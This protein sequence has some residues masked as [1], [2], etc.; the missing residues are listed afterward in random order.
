MGY[1][2]EPDFAQLFTN[3]VL[4]TA[5]GS[6]RYDQVQQ[7][8]GQKIED[9]RTK[10]DRLQEEAEKARKKEQTQRLLLLI[11]IWAIGLVACAVITKKLILAPITEEE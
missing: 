1:D 7:D 8:L 5:K 11:S 10:K 3:I 9:A 6:T 4:W 2:A